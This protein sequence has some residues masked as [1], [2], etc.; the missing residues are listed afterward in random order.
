[1]AHVVHRHEAEL[2]LESVSPVL[3]TPA[4]ADQ[5]GSIL[6][7]PLWLWYG[8][9][10]HSPTIRGFTI[11]CTHES[12]ALFLSKP[13]SPGQR[14]LICS[15]I[16]SI[17]VITPLSSSLAE[18][19]PPPGSLSIL[20]LFPGDIDV[21]INSNCGSFLCISPAYSP[22]PGT[23]KHSINDC[24]IN[25]VKYTRND[26]TASGSN[27]YF[28]IWWEIKRCQLIFKIIDCSFMSVLISFFSSL[29]EH[30]SS[31]YPS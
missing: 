6:L 10:L 22:G 14:L 12:S 2:G 16:L 24:W 15:T 4:P 18:T 3:L 28:I 8:P 26:T 11:Q 7:S 21:S 1:M 5:G 25:S 19:I 30:R 27:R 29:A 9:D 31:S 17:R 20:H 13:S 23:E